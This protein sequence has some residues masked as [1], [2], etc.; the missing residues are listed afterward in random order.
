MHK[1]EERIEKHQEKERR[2]EKRE[3]TWH[4][5]RKEGKGRKK[6]KKSGKMVGREDR[7][8]KYRDEKKLTST[9][10]ST[11]RKTHDTQ[12]PNNPAGITSHIFSYT[13]SWYRPFIV[14]HEVRIAA[15][16]SNSHASY[17]S[18]STVSTDSLR[19]GHTPVSRFADFTHPLLWKFIMQE[20]REIQWIGLNAFS[21]IMK[22]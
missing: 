2:G 12:K 22:N 18:A 13:A 9:R 19:L 17:N 1:K 21:Q 16:S 6:M 3:K 8:V 14:S 7:E 4:M 10:R 20:A 5:K 15:L 11:V